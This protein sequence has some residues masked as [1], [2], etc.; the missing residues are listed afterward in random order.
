MYGNN[1]HAFYIYHQFSLE[2][3]RQ[4]KQ[5]D[6]WGVLLG[7]DAV[8]RHPFR[9]PN[10]PLQVETMSQYFSGIFNLYIET[11]SILFR[12]HVHVDW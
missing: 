6:E 5:L 9:S 10:G 12:P 4:R 11:M 7:G 1:V 3:T 8:V 2:T